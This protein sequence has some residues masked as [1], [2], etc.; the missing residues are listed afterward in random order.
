V[1]PLRAR[2][3][4][5]KG[6]SIS[7]TRVATAGISS[8][9]ERKPHLEAQSAAPSPRAVY[10]FL[11]L[12]RGA[13]VAFAFVGFLRLAGRFP[14]VEDDAPPTANGSYLSCHSCT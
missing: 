6:Q 5:G 4:F 14:L 2:G 8:P 1:R 3:V 7:L 10:V 12:F 9:L 11:G 13:V